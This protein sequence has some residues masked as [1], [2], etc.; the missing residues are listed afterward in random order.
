MKNLSMFLLML[1]TQAL[2]AQDQDN[3]I[4][5]LSPEKDLLNGEALPGPQHAVVEVEPVQLGVSRVCTQR[6]S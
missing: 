3:T 1:I 5:F 4:M 6:I 2:V